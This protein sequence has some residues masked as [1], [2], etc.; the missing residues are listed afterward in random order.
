MPKGIYKH[1]PLSEIH[2]DNIRKSME[3]IGHRPP[4]RIG[5]KHSDITKQRIRDGNLNKKRSIST[6]LKMSKAK[7]GKPGFWK[8]R[9]RPNMSIEHR[10]KISEANRGEKAWNW[11]GGL[12]LLKNLIRESFKYRQW[13]SDVFTRDNFTCQ[14]CGHHG[15]NLESHHKKAF[16]KILYEY[17]IKTL[18]EALSCEELW[19]INNGK[20]LCQK[21]H[22]Q[23]ENYKGRSNKKTNK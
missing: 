6:R 1:K 5:Y 9:S 22:G 10:T 11:K 14:D 23:T 8:N 20:T 18:E 2:K 15:G 13:R 21:C 7:L 4:A 17:S 12:T 3:R 19:N 16:S